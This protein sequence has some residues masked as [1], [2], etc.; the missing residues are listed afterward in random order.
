[1]LY[2]DAK[3]LRRAGRLEAALAEA[4]RGARQQS[5]RKSAWHWRFRL[6]TAELLLDR[7]ES[8]RALALLQGDS[9]PTDQDLRARREMDLGYAWFWLSKREEARR[10]LD[11]AVRLAEH[12]TDA[13]L[14]AEIEI[15]HAVVQD[16]FEKTDAC[17]RAALQL[18]LRQQDLF[19]IAIT[20]AGLG[21][22]RV[23]YSRYDEAIP[24]LEA[25]RVAAQESGAQRLLG[26]TLGN[27]GTA[28]ASLGDFDR[29]LTLLE[30]AA[31]I[32]A[33]LQDKRNQ[34]FWLANMG[35]IYQ[36]RRDFPN[37]ISSLRRAWSL[38]EGR[39]DQAWLATV[40]N[41]L[42]E[43]YLDAGDLSAAKEFSGRSLALL[44]RIGDP[45]HMLVYSELIAARIESTTRPFPLAEASLRRVVTEAEKQFEARPLWEAHAALAA[46]Y[47]S[48][49]RLS[50]AQAEYR[51]AIST[52]DAEWSKLRRDESKITFLANL[53][54]F[55]Q[56]YVD[57]LAGQGQSTDALRVAES[58][59]AR[60][61]EE[62]L[63][64]RH[65][66]PNSNQVADLQ[67]GLAGSRTVL[68]VYWLAPERSFL[69]LIT[70]DS[71]E[72]FPLPPAD[73]ITH[74]VEEYNS[75]LINRRDP[76]ERAYP[77]SSRLYQTLVRPMESHVKAGWSVVIVPDG[78]LHNLNFE[79]VVV[80]TPKPH[81]WIDDA[82]ISVAP[83]LGTLRFAPA[84]STARPRLL[85]I[86]DPIPPG[87]EYPALPHLRGELEILERYFPAAS[88]RI[89]ARDQ[90]TPEAYR[91][92]EPER[93]DVIHFAAH[94]TA[95]PESPLN[96]AVVLSRSGEAYKLYAKDVLNLPIRARL[97]T[98][99]ACSSAG[100]RAY[101]GEGLMGFSWAFL[102]A[103]AR[104]VVA[105]LW[106]VD[107]AATSR[108][109]GEFYQQVARGAPPGTALR[110]AK[111]SLLHSGSLDRK[112]FFW[113]PFV[114][115]TRFVGQP[116]SVVASR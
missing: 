105:G 89:Y 17:Y 112:P 4:D 39:E 41:R 113:A 37:A 36:R 55:Y 40:L 6:L 63:A 67:A 35:R 103:G 18:A 53:I 84:T 16:S 27:L 116:L 98:I 58:A 8:K 52:I 21:Y 95:N 109:M 45:A 29:A 79:S 9:A 101:F 78:A 81:Y 108:L 3:A 99:S 26:N 80:E 90:A 102:E 86:G 32:A 91:K 56:Q 93:Y 46:L 11:D 24:W 77:I 30:R 23:F 66:T 75:L 15:R 47:R 72:Q 2:R 62:R 31:N 96:S 74:M 69:W 111:L 50:D 44:R 65:S 1:M 64:V 100:P 43:V 68:A 88:R 42:A 110:R 83:S 51:H 54:Q 7:G 92:A 10:C 61:L 48:N 22:N 76:T 70:A 5:D 106:D 19:L 82:T 87:N 25:A 34:Q 28:Y 20:Y 60:V 71:C 94:A 97:V 38:A 107:D 85:L 57:F 114:V 14:R 115:F 33:Q 12:S 59:R 73:E 13:D 104:H 49:R